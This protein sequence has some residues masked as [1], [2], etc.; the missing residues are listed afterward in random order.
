MTTPLEPEIRSFLLTLRADNK[1]AKTSATYEE[2]VRQF[3]ATLPDDVELAGIT[4]NHV[5]AWIV[6][7]Q[8][9]GRSPATVSVRF[10]S[11]QQ[12]FKWAVDEGDID[13][14]PM[15]GM[16]RPTVPTK[17]VPVI[18]AETI[19][20]MLKACGGRDFIARR[21][22]AVISFLYDTGVRAAECAGL[23][24]FDVNLAEGYAD[25][26]MATAKGRKPRRVPFGPKTSRDLDRYLRARAKHA[27]AHETAL[28]LGDNGCG[29][30]KS[31]L[32]HMI[33]RRGRQ[34]GIEG[35]HP[36]QFRHT[37]AHEFLDGGGSEGDLMRLAG[38]A[39]RDMLDRYGASSAAKRA[40]DAHRRL[41]PRDRLAG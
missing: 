39:S 14:S 21:D 12:F 18:E 9:R 17:P 23:T 36:H 30:S 38:W 32:Q 29:F 20:R 15:A 1:S 37:F 22:R 11:L 13:V 35:L 24:V 31:A 34:V 16:K 5:R 41:S 33:G 2:S 40:Q 10:R 4:R 25:I 19:E 28:W 26:S 27:R 3:A 6:D 7:L 8:D